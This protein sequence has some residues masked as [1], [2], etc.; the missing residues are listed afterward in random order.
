MTTWPLGHQFELVVS[1]DIDSSCTLV[2]VLPARHQLDAADLISP[3]SAALQLRSVL[4]SARRSFS[5]VPRLRWSRGWPGTDGPLGLLVEARLHRPMGKLTAA[6]PDELGVID[7]QVY[8]SAGLFAFTI[9]EL[10][11]VYR[12]RPGVKA[13]ARGGAQ[14]SPDVAAWLLAQ[15]TG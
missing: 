11:E 8:D 6:V 12:R 14:L 1:A 13:P 2:F 7:L 3:G 10:G 4:Q 15:P 9:N 5:E